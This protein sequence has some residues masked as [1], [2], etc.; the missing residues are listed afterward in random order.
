MKD[1]AS[2]LVPVLLPGRGRLAVLGVVAEAGAAEVAADPALV[3]ARFVAVRAHVGRLLPGR[4]G[5]PGVV[6]G[7]HPR[8][9]RVVASGV[10]GRAL[11]L[12]VLA[13]PDDVL[14][15]PAA[16]VLREGLPVQQ[17]RLP[18]GDRQVCAVS[19]VFSLQLQ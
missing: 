6:L 16:D 4:V 17:E 8:A 12:V 9:D 11:G 3:V 14:G 10:S 19:G 1:A 2:P 7:V 15:V 18:R 5:G 13:V